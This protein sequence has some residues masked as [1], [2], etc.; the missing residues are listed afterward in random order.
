MAHAGQCFCGAVTIEASGEPREMG[1]C[2]CA[3][4]RVWS[5]GPINSFTLWPADAVKVT[6]GEDKIGTFAKTDFS[7]RKHCTV[8]GGHIMVAHPGLG[9]MD[10]CAVIL[11]TLAFKPTV[12]LNYPET[13]LPMKDGL[14]K[15][16]DF[17][18][19]A[20]GSGEVVPE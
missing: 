15:L 18:K 12:H 20:G 4:C 6:K 19:E 1:Y 16:K 7:H 17:P 9:L 10:V 13:V 3:S 2:H 8:C 5:G 14:P 11:P